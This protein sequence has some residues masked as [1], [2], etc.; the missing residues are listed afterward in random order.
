MVHLFRLYLVNVPFMDDYVWLPFYEK[1]AK[2][3][4]T[5]SDFFFVQMEHRLTVPC[6]LAWLCNHLS[7]GRITWHNWI[8][9]GELLLT[10]FNLGFLICR[11]CG[12]GWRVRLPLIAMT[13]WLVF[14]PAQFSTLLWSDCFSSFMPT[15][16]LTSALVI[17]HLRL[18]PTLK[19]VLC[20]V[21]A[22]L[23][24]HSFA[25]GIQVWLLMVP[26]I[27]WSDAI[28]GGIVRKRFFMAW[29]LAA[30]IT[31]ALYF[32]GLTNQAQEEFSYHQGH[33]ETLTKHMGAFIGSPINSSRFVLIFAGALL[34][35]GSFAD[36]KDATLV[37]GIALVGILIFSIVFAVRHFKDSSLRTRLLPW[38]A[39]GVYT[40][41][42]GAM[43]GLG[44]LYASLNM[45]GALWNRYTVH[46]VPISVSAVVMIFIVCSHLVCSRAAL[47]ETLH[48]IQSGL[49]G[50]FLI[51]LV[52]GWSYGLK[53]MEAWNSSRLRDATCQLFAKVLDHS[54]IDGPTSGNLHYASRMDDLGLLRPAM[55]KDRRLSNF[56]F[57]EAAISPRTARLD[58]LETSGHRKFEAEGFAFL[59]GHE[60]V[61]DGVFLTYRDEKDQWVIFAVGQVKEPPMYL[62]RFLS[63]DMQFLHQPFKSF[64]HVYGA[65]NIRF[66]IEEIPPGRREIAAWAFDFKKQTARRIPGRFKI[67]T[68]TA[69]SV[70][71]GDG[72]DLQ[73]DNRS[74]EP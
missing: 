64:R 25:S 15:T 34:G 9:F 48:R 66:D 22:V 71:F 41:G 14:S 43:V 44:R 13:S 70:P 42:T 1:I 29:G 39:L 53:Q 18:I 24:S 37:T 74:K 6:F 33:E 10:L 27:L 72:S 8:S 55:L 49:S 67:D 69:T 50:A 12:T 21:C 47:Q 46:A 60:R 30:V 11:T 17:F 28:V 73:P 61:A 20:A 57:S 36:V 19:F 5:F 56:N 45:D 63:V 68:A 52:C 35:R 65:F 32:H 59:P 51:L 26:L 54:D 23:A 3:E 62:N 31:M 7:P 16:F 40:C 4:F 58:V 2:R 38:L